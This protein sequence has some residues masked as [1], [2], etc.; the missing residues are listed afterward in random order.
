MDGPGSGLQFDSDLQGIRLDL[1]FLH[2]GKN[3]W[4]RDWRGGR[5]R[6][7]GLHLGQA[8]YIEGGHVV[9]VLVENFGRAF[10]FRVRQHR[11]IQLK[12]EDR[13]SSVS[14][15]LLTILY[16]FYEMTPSGLVKHGSPCCLQVYSA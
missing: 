6:L 3:R 2:L 16:L 5:W 13:Q 7:L 1:R 10:L 9:A 15:P 14:N 12:D 11:G 4:K 8:V